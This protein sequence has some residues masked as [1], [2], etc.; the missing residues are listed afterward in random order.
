MKFTLSL[1][2]LLVLIFALSLS[3]F[4]NTINFY[5]MSGE[6][7]V[8]RPYV[9]ITS[10][11]LHGSVLHLLSNIFVLLFFGMALEG[12]IKGSRTFVLFLAGGILGNILALLYY[13]PAQI[14]IG[15]SGGIFAIVGAGMLLKP[16]DISFYPFITPVPLAFLGI[17]YIAYNIYGFFF[18]AGSN[19]SYI[20]HFGGLFI[21][22][23][24]AF[25]KQGIKKSLLIL[26]F[27]LLL[28]YLLAVFL[29]R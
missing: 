19:I 7:F 28:M 24:Y 27:S 2:L 18:D 23:T 3:D 21:G 5:G 8:E 13:D 16:F 6:N 20:A 4:E 11:F 29:L 17:A 15:A 22:L 9:M 1:I 12:E 26:G 10:I 14:G 25:H